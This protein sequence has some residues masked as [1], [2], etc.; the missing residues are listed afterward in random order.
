MKALSIRGPWWWFILHLPEHQRKDV[1]NRDWPRLT[2]HRGETLIHASSGVTR[3]E[4]ED[5]CEFAS[6]RC[7]VTR[8]PDFETM[9]RGGIVGIVNIVAHVREH[10]SRWFMG[11]TGLVLENPYPE[12][13]RPCPGMLG[14][15]DP[16]FDPEWRPKGKIYN[17]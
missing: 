14:F 16:Q 2:L 1:E 5:A 8:F 12:P 11:P 15:F 10:S 13:F 3:R 6:K 4:F 9:H 7:R 17:E